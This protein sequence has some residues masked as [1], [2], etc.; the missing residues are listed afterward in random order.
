M[1]QHLLALRKNP[2]ISAIMAAET[3][4][5]N[6]QKLAYSF[7][8]EPTQTD[9]YL[10][11]FLGTDEAITFLQSLEQSP[12]AHAVKLFPRAASSNHNIFHPQTCDPRTIDEVYALFGEKFSTRR[13]DD[14]AAN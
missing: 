9:L 1:Y 7:D 14:F 4:R 2:R 3:V 5:D 6:Q 12:G 10:T 13:Y 11:H 8:R